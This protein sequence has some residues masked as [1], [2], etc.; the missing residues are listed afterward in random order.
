MQPDSGWKIYIYI[1]VGGLETWEL[2][3]VSYLKIFI[4]FYINVSLTFHK[5]PNSTDLSWELGRASP[6]PSSLLYHY[7]CC[8]DNRFLFQWA[9]FFTGK[10][11]EVS[12]TAQWGYYFQSLP[13]WQERPRGDPVA[14]LTCQPLFDNIGL[15]NSISYYCS[16]DRFSLVGW[17]ELLWLNSHPGGTKVLSI[18]DNP[19]ECDPVQRTEVTVGWVTG[20]NE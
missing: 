18:Q 13:E 1:K 16:E 7:F 5:M 6:H 3:E 20:K 10:S 19:K 8:R 17:D 14:V 11:I 4:H 12:S 15:Q 9:F 2:L